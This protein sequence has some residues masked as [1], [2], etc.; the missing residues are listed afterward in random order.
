ML[1][2]CCVLRTH[3]AHAQQQECR[4]KQEHTVAAFFLVDMTPSE[5]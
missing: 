3:K 2:E 4:K 5:L 1:R